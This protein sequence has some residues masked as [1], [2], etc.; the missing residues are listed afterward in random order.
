MEV[1]LRNVNPDD[2][3]FVERVYFETQRWIIEQLFG[4]RGEDVERAKF[5]E[6]YLPQHSCVIMADGE[7]IGWMT[8]LDEADAIELEAIYITPAMQR[9]GIGTRLMS[10]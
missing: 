10:R 1:T 6:S 9:R 3:A 5:E 4:W 2:R 7:P 8:V